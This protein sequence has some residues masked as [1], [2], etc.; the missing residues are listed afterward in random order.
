MRD[1]ANRAG[2]HSAQLR[3]AVRVTTQG[4]RNQQRDDDEHR[5][6]ALRKPLPQT[7]HIF[8]RVS[9]RTIVVKRVVKYVASLQQ[10]VAV[11]ATTVW[12][13]ARRRLDLPG[14]GE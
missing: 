9:T 11:L 5:A 3:V 8:A 7:S 4:E 10:R 6:G 14:R 13:A 1:D 2:I 12:W